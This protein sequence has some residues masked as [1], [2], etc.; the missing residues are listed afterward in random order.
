MSKGCMIMQTSSMY[1]KALHL[2]YCSEM[3]KKKAKD[4]LYT[5]AYV[6]KKML[7]SFQR[8]SRMTIDHCIGK[9]H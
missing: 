3:R 5:S 9:E 6:R 4:D 2:K 8:I 7:N 1:F